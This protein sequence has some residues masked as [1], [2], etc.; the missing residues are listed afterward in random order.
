[1]P[2]WLWILSVFIALSFGYATGFL[3]GSWKSDRAPNALVWESV[4]KSAISMN[5]EC[6]MREM[7]L[8]HEE[9]MELI[10]RGAFDPVLEKAGYSEEEDDD[11]DD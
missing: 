7:E 1:M 3:A 6:A 9:Q 5:K 8:N 10:K 11:D 2:E 4:R